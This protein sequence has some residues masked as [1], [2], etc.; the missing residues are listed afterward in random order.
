L[1]G[2]ARYR[3]R[4]VW[5]RHV[6]DALWAGTALWPVLA[7]DAEGRQLGPA[8][9]AVLLTGALLLTRQLW[10]VSRHAAMLVVPLA[11]LAAYQA[12]ALL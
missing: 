5:Q 7:M 4:T 6:I 1:L 9:A 3:L 8:S 2:L 12:I 10:P 11:A